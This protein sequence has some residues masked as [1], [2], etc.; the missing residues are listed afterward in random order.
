MKHTLLWGAALCAALVF[1]GCPTDD[2][3]NKDKDKDKENGFEGKILK[4]TDIPAKDNDDEDIT[5]IAAA[6]IKDLNEN[7]PNP[8][9]SAF[10]VLDGTTG[11]FNLYE[12]TSQWAP[13]IT[14]PWTGSGAYYLILATSMEATAPQYF[15]TAGKEIVE[16]NIEAFKQAVQTD[17]AALI[18]SMQQQGGGQQGESPGDGIGELMG[19]NNQPDQEK[20][21]AYITKKITA[22]GTNTVKQNMTPYNFTEKVSTIAWDQFR[23]LDRTAI[24]TAATEIVS[25]Q[26]TQTKIQSVL[27][28][29]LGALAAQLAQMQQQSGGG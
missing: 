18:A 13:D 26:A 21:S 10:N 14:K 11:T 3:N 15:Y 7:S 17:I 24:Q 20:V 8:E 28:E 23:L 22:L 5:I 6:L 9:V 12:A 27:T 16:F 4:V 2:N 19:Q 25:A 1:L 29:Q